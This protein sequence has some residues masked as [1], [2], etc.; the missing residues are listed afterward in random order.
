[1]RANIHIHMQIAA[2]S[3]VCTGIA[4][5]TDIEDAFVV[6]SC[7]NRNLNGLLSAQ[8][9]RSTAIRAGLFDN[10]SAAPAAVTA[11]GTL[12]NAKWGTLI[13]PRCV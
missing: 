8:M 12:D 7:R 5:S 3:A 11:A 1:M 2:R 13:D 6:D 9:T 10:F 4:H